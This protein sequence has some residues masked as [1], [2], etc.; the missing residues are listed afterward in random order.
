MRGE[1]GSAR[2]EANFARAAIRRRQ[3]GSGIEYVGRETESALPW[4]LLLAIIA[5]I[6]ERRQDEPA[7]HRLAGKEA[8]RSTGRRGSRM[9]RTIS[10]LMKTPPT[11]R[12]RPVRPRQAISDTRS[13]RLLA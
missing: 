3:P 2:V 5:E 6:E 7:R 12:S 4:I 13:C 11:A 8:K 1:R 9:N 10:A